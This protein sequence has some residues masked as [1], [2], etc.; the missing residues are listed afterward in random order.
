MMPGFDLS[1]MTGSPSFQ[2][3]AGGAATSGDIQTSNSFAFDSSG[4]T[5]GSGSAQV[6]GATGL[7]PWLIGGAAL[8]V[9]L[10]IL[11]RK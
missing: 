7:N 8:L 10:W 9:A 3:G 11:R 6:T 5:V 4:W 2:G 1:G